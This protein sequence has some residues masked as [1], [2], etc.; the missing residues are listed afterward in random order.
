MCLYIPL[1]FLDL[2]DRH[3]YIL[4]QSYEALDLNSHA[5]L[6]Y[7]FPDPN[8]YRKPLKN[9]KVGPKKYSMGS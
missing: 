1:I 4:N 7:T 6:L 8:V 3:M 9:P 2:S 5:Y